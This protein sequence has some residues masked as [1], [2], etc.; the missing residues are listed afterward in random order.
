MRGELMSCDKQSANRRPGGQGPCRGARSGLGCGFPGDGVVPRAG[1]ILPSGIRLQEHQHLFGV[2]LPIGGQ[3]QLAVR[4]HDPVQ[5]LQKVRLNDTTF[6]VAFFGPGIR[7]LD[8][9]QSKDTVW[10]GTQPRYD[11]VVQY[12]QILQLQRFSAQQQGADAGAVDLCTHTAPVRML[13]RK[14]REVLAIA[15][16]NFQH[17]GL[18]AGPGRLP[19]LPGI[20][21]VMAAAIS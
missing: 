4:L 12:P 17:Q 2:G 13:L 1:Q 5:H 18:G 21:N 19:G 10:Q 20:D 3:L 16:A 9:H 6:V 14:L 8:D 7:K 15:K 11:V